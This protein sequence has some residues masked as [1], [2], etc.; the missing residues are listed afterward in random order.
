MAITFK[1]YHD[2][3]LTSEVTSGNPIAITALHPGGSATD[4][5]LWL[6]STATDTQAQ[7]NSDPGVDDIEISIADS[8]GGGAG[9]ATT[10]CK[11]ATSQGGLSTA[12]AGDPLPIGP[13]LASGVAKAMPFW[14]RVT[15]AQTVVGT[16]TDLSLATNTL[17][18]SP[19]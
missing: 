13:T 19:V 4:V 14:L 17:V 6:G 18:E 11:L 16:Y 10:A 1:F 9:N 2:A 8:D 5:Q 12:V 7:A 3:A 15:N